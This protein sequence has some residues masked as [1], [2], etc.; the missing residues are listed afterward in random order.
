MDKT[1]PLSDLLR[2][3]HCVTPSKQLHTTS[4]GLTKYM[5]ESLC[6]TIG[7]VGDGKK[8]LN[9]IENIHHTLHFDLKR[10]SK[11]DFPRESARNGALKNSL[12]STTERRGNMFRL[13]SLCHI[14]AAHQDLDLVFYWSSINSD[15][16]F[17]VS[18]IKYING[19]VVPREQS[20]SRSEF[21]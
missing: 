19:R 3:I 8:L 9:K 20:K 18:Q 17:Q 5:I 1:L 4:E 2:V 7:D 10:N 21:C 12:F 16:F 15:K 6:N 13:L 11:P 14:D